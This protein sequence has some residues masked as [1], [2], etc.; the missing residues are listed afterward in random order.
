M[1]AEFDKSVKTHPTLNLIGCSGEGAYSATKDFVWGEG[2]VGKHDAHV[3]LGH[4]PHQLWLA[5]V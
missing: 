5:V 4:R 3:A 2:D 1:D